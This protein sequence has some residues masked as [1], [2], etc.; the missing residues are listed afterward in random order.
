MKEVTSSESGFTLLEVVVAIAIITMLTV[1]F[2]PLIVSSVQRIQWAG[3]RMQELY[4]LRSEMEKSLASES[5][6][7]TSPEISIH[8]QVPKL[9]VWSGGSN[10][11]IEGLVVRVGD[12]VSFLPEG[13]GD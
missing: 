12:F 7:K 5:Y 9:K 1:A 4:T 11:G 3:I 2:A 10:T 6:A 8:K 13:R